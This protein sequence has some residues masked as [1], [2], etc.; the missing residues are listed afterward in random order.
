M[1]ENFVFFDKLMWRSLLFFV[2]GTFFGGFCVDRVVS[3]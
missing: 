2:G 1:D 3:W